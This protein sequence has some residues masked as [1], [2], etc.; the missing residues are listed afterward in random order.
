MNID[1]VFQTRE[2]AE[3]EDRLNELERFAHKRDRFLEGLNTSELGSN[4]LFTIRE[5][6]ERI[7]ETIAF[8][9]FYLIHLADLD[10]HAC[11]L[12]LAA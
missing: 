7:L 11:E 5:D 12:R 9:H 4:H 3:A 10:A 2:L 1:A 6:D 8:G